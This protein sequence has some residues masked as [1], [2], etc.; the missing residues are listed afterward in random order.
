MT[1]KQ[2]QTRQIYNYMAAGNTITGIEALALFRC[3]RLPARVADLKEEGVPV[4]DGWEYEYKDGK[5]VRKWKKYW[6][7]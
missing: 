5:V 3:M 1:E 2:A 7:Q 4:Q 6:I